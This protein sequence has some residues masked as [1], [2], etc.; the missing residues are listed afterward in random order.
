MHVLNIHICNSVYYTNR[1]VNL[2]TSINHGE[3]KFINQISSTECI[4]SHCE[5]WCTET[6]RIC[7]YSCSL[8]ALVYYMC[9][10]VI[11]RVSPRPLYFSVDTSNN[12]TSVPTL[13]KNLSLN[14]FK[15]SIIILTFRNIYHPTSNLS[16]FCVL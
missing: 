8:A 2:T 13:R 16:L 1:K 4:N 12:G 9:T 10:C 7:M 15:R 5:L 3:A 14:P 6:T 11:C